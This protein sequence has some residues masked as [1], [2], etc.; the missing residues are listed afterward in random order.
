MGEALVSAE[1][2]VLAWGEL[3]VA[4]SPLETPLPS[5]RPWQYP[6]PLERSRRWPLQLPLE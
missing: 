3:L 2:A 5:E 6:S 1:D 4:V